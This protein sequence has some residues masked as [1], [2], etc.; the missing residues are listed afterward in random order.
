MSK[1]KKDYKEL[2]QKAAYDPNHKPEPE[3]IVIK[4]EGKN[5]GAMENFIT[6]TGLP[7]NGKGRYMAAIAAGG[8]SRKEIFGIST[9]LPE[10][11]EKVAYFDTEQGSWD[12]YKA[13]DIIIGL[14]G[15]NRVPEN[16][17]PFNIREHEP[18][19]IVQMIDTY[20]QLTPDCG[21]LMLDGLLDLLESF[22][23]E[24]ESK[25]LINTLKRWTKVYKC[26]APCVLHRGKTTGTTLGQLGGIA[27]RASQSIL[28]VEKIK[29][30]GTYQLRPD[31]L[32]SAEDFTPI[33]IL[34]DTQSGQWMETNFIPV[35]DKKV[36]PIKLKPGEMDMDTHRFN[37]LKIFNSEEIQ[38]YDMIVQ[39]IKEIYARG[40]DWSREC[41]QHLI[42]EGLIFK[43]QYG[44]TN[45]QKVKLFIK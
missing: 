24:G 12:Y 22:N 39:N 6:L 8:I 43:T 21:L 42:H 38:S 5:I 27:D 26:L 1:P 16:F 30:R 11:K 40:V 36:R 28:I 33:E 4:I 45:N 44:Y 25:R 35:D 32:R 7:K 19:D 3:Q 29:D 41:V 13:I 34:Y 10:G 9:K 17:T 23:D 20:L 31:Y 14:A 15:L 37:V 18:W 2:L